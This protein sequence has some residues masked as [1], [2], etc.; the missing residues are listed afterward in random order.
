MSNSPSLLG[1]SGSTIGKEAAC[2]RRRHKRHGFDLWWGR[3]PAVG[4]GNLLQ[5]SCLE[6][7]MDRR[8]WQATVHRVTKRQDWSGL[9]CK[10]CCYTKSGKSLTLRWC[11]RTA[12]PVLIENRKVQQLLPETDIGTSSSEPSE[13]KVWIILPDT[14]FRSAEVIVKSAGNLED[15]WQKS[16]II[17]IKFQPWDQV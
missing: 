12:Y 5:Y 7:P 4:N 10:G 6:N 15:L 3:S 2:R 1:G 11:T 17:T 13:M 14:P 9:A 8:D 16:Q